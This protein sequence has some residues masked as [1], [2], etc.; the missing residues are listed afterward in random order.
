MEKI[1]LKLI[2][3]TIDKNEMKYLDPLIEHFLKSKTMTLS[4]VESKKHLEYTVI[5]LLDKHSNIDNFIQDLYTIF[6]ADHH[7]VTT[8]S[9]TYKKIIIVRKNFL[10]LYDNFRAFYDLIELFAFLQIPIRLHARKPTL[11]KKNQVNKSDCMYVYYWK[12]LI[13]AD[14]LRYL[15]Y[16]GKEL[17]MHMKTVDSQVTYN[18][19]SYT[20]S[21]TNI[22]N[23]YDLYDDRFINKQNEIINILQKQNY[24]VKVIDS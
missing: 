10:S 2:D 22:Y 3:M 1:D 19:F 11:T 12:P 5:Y 7:C 17:A 4:L 24:Q 8:C 13:N 21:L 6:S 15:K 18:N 14:F 20:I 23:R 9:E 16:F